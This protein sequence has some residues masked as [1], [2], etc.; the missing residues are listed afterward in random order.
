MVH[1]LGREFTSENI[2]CRRNINFHTLNTH[3]ECIFQ[4]K[5]AYLTLELVISTIKDGLTGYIEY[6][7]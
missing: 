5:C 6:F 3:C 4:K 2:S 1:L 7:F